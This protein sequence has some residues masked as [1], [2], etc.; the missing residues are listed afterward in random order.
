MIVADANLLVHL[1]FPGEHSALADRIYTRDPDWAVPLLW[2]SE[3]RN[4][5][6]KFVRRKEITLT[7]A[8]D[9]LGRAS[10]VVVNREYSVST[11]TVLEL[12]ARSGCTAYDCE[13]VALAQA[14]AVPLVTADQAVLRAFPSIARPI[15]D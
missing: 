4:V 7:Q 2:V 9:A 13:Y 12:A 8:I 1:V 14:L 15:I 3:L 6:W 5:A 10:T 11:A